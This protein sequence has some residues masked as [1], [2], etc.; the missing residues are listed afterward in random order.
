MGGA[1]SQVSQV[2]P[3]Q[4]DADAIP[5]EYKFSFDIEG[6]EELSILLSSSCNF[7]ISFN[8][9]LRSQLSSRITVFVSNQNKLSE[10]RQ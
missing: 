4:A 10:Q 2:A 6:V 1:S 7:S 9:L 3:T 8:I 5:E